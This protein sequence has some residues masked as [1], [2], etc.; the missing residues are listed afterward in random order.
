[1]RL[2]ILALVS[3]LAAVALA[4]A[5]SSARAARPPTPTPPKIVD[6]S[7]QPGDTYIDPATKLT[8][9]AYTFTIEFTH[10]RGLIGFQVNEY[11][12]GGTE[13][14]AWNNNVVSESRIGTDTLTVELGSLATQR[15]YFKLF[16]Y[17]PEQFRP[18]P[19]PE[20]IY[21]SRTTGTYIG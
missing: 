1:M 8:Y 13:K 3:S 7:V 19:S 21:D 14:I 9:R 20:V 18:K 6:Y 17:K 16:L 5:T 12:A 10:Q 11:P 4:G 2:F 15:V